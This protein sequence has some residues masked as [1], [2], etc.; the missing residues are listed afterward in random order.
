MEEYVGALSD[1]LAWPFA[2]KGSIFPDSRSL[3]FC[4]NN[5]RPLFI[6]KTEEPARTAMAVLCI[7]IFVNLGLNTLWLTILQ[8][9]GFLVMLPDRAIRIA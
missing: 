6:Q 9:K 3:P 2:S 7:S 8:G 4:P 5:I 1:C